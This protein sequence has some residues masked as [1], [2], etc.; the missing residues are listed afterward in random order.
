[1]PSLIAGAAVTDISPTNS[2]FLYGYPHVERYSTGIHDPI[3]AQALYLADGKQQVM[4]IANDIIFVSK[5]S[6]GRIRQ[7]INEAT[8]IP[9]ANIMVTATHTHS[10]P[11]TVDHLITEAD[12]IVPKTD[13]AYLKHFEDQIVAAG[14]GAY[15]KRQPAKAGLAVATAKGVGTHRHDPKGPADPQVPVLMVKSVD[16]D[17]P[18]AAMVVYSM[19]PTVLHEDSKLVSGDF[20]AMTRQYL[21]KTLLGENCPVLYHVGNTGN[22]SPR[23][24]T[25]GNTFA[26]AERLGNLLGESIAKVIPSIQY[27]SDLKVS[28]AQAFVDLPR[29]QLPPVAQAEQGEHNARERLAH[30]RKINAPRTE[31]RTAE[32]DWFGS[33]ETLTLAKAAVDGR[34][35]KSFKVFLPA[36]VQV[37]GVGDWSFVGWPGESFVE[38]GLKVKAKCPNTFVI[39]LANGELG[40]YLVTEE[41]VRENWYEGTNASLKSP[42]SGEK[43]VETTVKLLSH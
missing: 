43:I 33:E 5:Q 34:L 16:G 40:G 6:T 3:L 1:M 32:C 11:I 22:Q 39:T 26:E 7:R 29:R 42:E 35:E 27:R 20:P 18:I 8:G 12:P 9:Q 38:F 30:L 28:S 25:K 10:G 13:Q 19:H 2:Q 4:F 15:Q 36:E 41:A 14:V 21:Q 37:I 17:K 31:V 23:H 24:V